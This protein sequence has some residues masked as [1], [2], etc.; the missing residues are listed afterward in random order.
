[1]LGGSMPV[2][3]TSGS[4][5]VKTSP[6]AMGFSPASFRSR[7]LTLPVAISRVAMMASCF[8]NAVAYN[9]PL[10]SK[11][12]TKN[13]MLTDFSYNSRLLKKA[14][15]GV[16]V[17]LLAGCINTG[18][19]TKTQR[20]ELDQRVH[21]RWLALEQKDFEKAWEYNSPSYRAIFSKQ[22][23]ARKFSYAVEW[24]LTG[25]EI[26]NYDGVA[27]VASV[28]VRVMS[29]PTKQTSSVSLA[30]GAIPTTRS[31]RWIFA[32]RQWWFSANY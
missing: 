11:M 29:K 25:V 26:V 5:S 7:W 19:L 8:V 21:E 4:R 9:P 23:Y 3:P 15:L 20:S 27:A 24:E 6:G 18:Q 1:M 16:L 17:V 22:L 10:N 30:I 2:C 12:V 28:V 31:E 13:N 14:L 32:E